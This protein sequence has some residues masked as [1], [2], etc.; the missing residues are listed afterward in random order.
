MNNRRRQF[1]YTPNTDRFWFAVQNPTTD[2]RVY[3]VAGETGFRPLKTQGINE[4]SNWKKLHATQPN[5]ITKAALSASM[6][7]WNTPV[8][9]RALTWARSLDQAPAS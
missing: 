7:G 6:Y 5:D 9:A 2:E 8:G 4:L 1:E 3:V